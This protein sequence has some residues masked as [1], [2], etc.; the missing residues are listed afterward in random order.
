[1]PGEG[2][3]GGWHA[4][5]LA[6]HSRVELVPAVRGVGDDAVVFDRELDGL[7]IG[8]QQAG[9]LGRVE[10]GRQGAGLVYQ[11]VAEPAQLRQH[12]AQQSAPLAGAERV[13]FGPQEVDD[14][15]PLLG[16][17]VIALRQ[18]GELANAGG[19]VGEQ[20]RLRRAA[21][22]SRCFRCCLAIGRPPG[23]G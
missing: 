17:G 10:V 22:G 6:V 16:P 19:Q 2:L 9:A 3:V 8:P 20:R 14:T 11:V 21:V 18:V 5:R 13:E 1:V 4:A 23:A 15:F 7:R 12:R